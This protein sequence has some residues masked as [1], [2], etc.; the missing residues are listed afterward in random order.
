LLKYRIIS[1]P[2]LLALL[3]GIFF[4]TEGGPWLFA[5]AAAVLITT[6]LYELGKLAFAAGLPNSPLSLGIA[7][8]I[9]V[10]LLLTPYH[11]RVVPLREGMILFLLFL[12][13][14]FWLA[15]LGRRVDGAKK[16]AA[17][18]GLFFFGWIPLIMLA[19][20]YR[21]VSV[22][23]FAFVVLTTKAMDTGGYIFG[24]LT[25]KLPWG[26]HK[27]APSISPGKSVEG[28]LGGLLLSLLVGWLFCSCETLHLWKPLP[29]MLAAGIFSIGSFLGDLTE[30][31]LKRAAEVKDSGKW[32]PG[33]GGTLDLIDSFLYNGMLFWLLL[34]FLKMVK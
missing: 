20:I 9:S 11:I 2:L 3:A 10:L 22:L 7:G 18:F 19:L 23:A 21:H 8:F 17:T 33:M 5:I 4:W 1:F 16:C 29:T 13:F 14:C 34:P 32:L 25:A 6:G 31:S 12:L 15:V 27:I 28:F 26:N 30:S 24:N